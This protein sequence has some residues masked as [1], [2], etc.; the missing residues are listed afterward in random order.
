LDAEERDTPA[1]GIGPQ[2]KDGKKVF[3]FFSLEFFLKI[4]LDCDKNGG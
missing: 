3:I 4:Y 2:S 1:T